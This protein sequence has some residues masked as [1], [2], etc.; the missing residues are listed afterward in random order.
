MEIYEKEI[1]DNLTNIIRDQ[2]SIAVLCPISSNHDFQGDISDSLSSALASIGVEQC[3]QSDLYYLNSVL[4]SAGWNKN[5]D[6]FEVVDL[7]DARNTPVNKPF[8]YMHDETDIIGHMTAS[9]VMGPDG[10]LVDDS[11]PVDQLPEKVDIITS[12]VIYKSWGDP[13]L[14]NRTEEFIKQISD[15]ELSVSMEVFFKGFDYA[16]ITPDGEHKVIARDKDSA[17]LTKHLRSYGGSGEY[18]GYKVGRV[19]RNFYFV[20]KGLVDKPANP[21]SIIF[22]DSDPFKPTKADITFFSKANVENDMEIEQL[23]AELETAKAQASTLQSDNET[24][25]TAIADKNSAIASLEVKIKEMEDAIASL[26]N[27]KTT[28]ASELQRVVTEAKLMKRKASLV[29]A[30]A[31]EAKADEI[32][33]KFAEASDEMFESVVSLLSVAKKNCSEDKKEDMKDEDKKEDKDEDDCEASDETEALDD[34][35]VETEASF[36][37]QEEN[38]DEKTLASLANWFGTNVLKTT[39]KLNK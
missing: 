11:C 9:A 19:L 10:T 8:N 22:R 13:E 25:K 5:D 4:V 18:E 37:T 34:V 33:T 30:G 20:G 32:I 36:K 31:D 2:N 28:I 21:R 3:N 12:A 26:T 17:F 27:E 38:E 6:V 39:K 7:W 35:K 23:K 1:L 15:G 29:E 14:R 24:F 16:L